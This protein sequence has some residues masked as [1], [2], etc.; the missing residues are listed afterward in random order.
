MDLIRF[1][2]TYMHKFWIE[3]DS[4]KHFLTYE[5]SSCSIGAYTDVAHFQHNQTLTMSW[6]FF[7]NIVN[8]PWGLYLPKSCGKC[9]CIKLWSEWKL[10]N[11]GMIV[12]YCAYPSCKKKIE[13]TKPK[14]VEVFS[15]DIGIVKW[16]VI[17]K[18]L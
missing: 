15:R 3:A 14:G 12:G 10:Q 5:L 6:Y 9:A 7:S 16:Y 13:W 2:V 11:N 17:K 4:I 1:L 8:E 18:T